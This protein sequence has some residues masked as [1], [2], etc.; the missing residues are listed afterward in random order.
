MSVSM[1]EPIDSCGGSRSRR[2]RCTTPMNRPVGVSSGGRATNTIDA[3][4]GVR[5]CRRTCASAAAIGVSGPEDHRLG[6][7]QAAGGVVLVGQ[8]APDVLGLLGLHQL[9]QLGLLVVGQ[10]AQQVGGVVG[11]HGLEHVGG[12]RAGQALQDADLVVLGQLLEHVGEA[13]VVQRAGHLEPPRQAEVVQ[14]VGEVGG[15]E[16]LVL[17]EHAA[18]RPARRSPGRGP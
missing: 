1:I 2:C 3:S 7:H 6:G 14:D 17:R 13:L 11:L 16:V 18:R 9:E 5:S 12:A 4:A 8:Q 10:L 15:L